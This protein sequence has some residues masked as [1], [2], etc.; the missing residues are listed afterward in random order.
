MSTYIALSRFTDQ[1]IRTLKE[2]ASRLDAA[3]QAAQAMGVEIKG[4]YLVMGQYDLV[5]IFEAADDETF[6]KFALSIGA[7]G[8]VRTETLRAFLEDEYRQIIADL[9]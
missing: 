1:G 4:H 5:T 9:P 2:G 8:N 7:V 3:K 6:A